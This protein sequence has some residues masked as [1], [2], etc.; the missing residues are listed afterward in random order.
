MATA[1]QLWIMVDVETTGP[2]YGKHSLTEI[3]AAVGSMEQG[4]LD[5]FEAILRPIGD[6]VAASRD[7]CEKAL[8]VGLAPRDARQQF[9]HWSRPYREQ[10]ARFVARPAPF[11][12]P[13]IIYT[14]GATSVRI[15]MGSRR[16]VPPPG[17]K[18]GGS[19]LRSSYRTSPHA[20][21]KSSW[22]IF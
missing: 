21:G 16:Y 11:D 15:R 20:M 13:W 7:S 3:G 12:W 14:P 4:L 17:S 1:Q 19:G 2:V 6:E 22:S 5:R 10:K 8:Q 18:R 9:A